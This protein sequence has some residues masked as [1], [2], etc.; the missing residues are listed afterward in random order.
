MDF[1]N[2]GG[3]DGLTVDERI[4]QE[5]AGDDTMLI[6]TMDGETKPV[7]QQVFK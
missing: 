4:Q 5:Y 3:K 2:M 1:S 7:H 6:F